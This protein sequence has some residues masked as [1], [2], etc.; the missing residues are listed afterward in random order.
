MKN[1]YKNFGTVLKEQRFKKAW[2]MHKSI[3]FIQRH[4]NRKLPKL[5]EGY[6]YPGTRSSKVTVG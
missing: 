1:E 4:N 3:K 6:K 2:T 5:G